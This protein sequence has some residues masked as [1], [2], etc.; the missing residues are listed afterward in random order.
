ML[1]S[2][3][4]DDNE[5]QISDVVKENGEQCIANQR[6]KLGFSIFHSLN[7]NLNKSSIGIT[8][9]KVYVILFCDS[10]H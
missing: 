4:V 8:K 7:Y 1:F 5:P 9:N 3:I 10:I 2:T 6:E